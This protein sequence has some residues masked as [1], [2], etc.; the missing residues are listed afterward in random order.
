MADKCCLCGKT[1]IEGELCPRH[2]LLREQQLSGRFGTLYDPEY[3]VL[4]MD[5][6]TYA[7]DAQ[8]NPPA[9]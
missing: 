5:E 8:A 6:G 9:S 2:Y 3:I 4:Y 1:A 7:M